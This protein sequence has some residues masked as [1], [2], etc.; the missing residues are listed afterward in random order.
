[1]ARGTK[2]ADT[3]VAIGADLTAYN[4]GLKQAEQGA[5]SL[6][7]KIREAFRMGPGGAARE[8]LLGPFAQDL[9]LGRKLSAS[10]RDEFGRLGTSARSVGTTIRGAFSSAGMAAFHAGLSGIKT[11]L[12]GIVSAAKEVGKGLLLGLGAAG[13]LQIAEWVAQTVQAIPNLINRGKEYANVVQE[14]AIQTGSSTERV[15]MLAAT[16]QYLGV[17]IQAIT[18]TVTTFSRALEGNEPLLK[19]LGVSLTDAAGKSLDAVTI[20]DRVRSAFSK[21]PA[22]IDRTKLAVQLF[23]E[24]GLG[25]MGQY[26]ALTDEQVAALGGQ[27]QAQALIIGDAEGKIALDAERAWSNVGNSLTGLGATLATAVLPTLTRVFD[28]IATLI[29]DNAAAIAEFAQS[30]IG[31]VVGLV[32]ALTGIQVNMA[33]FTQSVTAA[34]DVTGEGSALLVSYNAELSV[35]EGQLKDDAKAQDGSSEARKRGTAAIDKQIAALEKLERQQERTYKAALKGLT[36]QLDAQLRLM[37][38]QDQAR[39][40]ADEDKDLQERILDARLALDAIKREIAQA[41]TDRAQGFGSG[42]TL[43]QRTR[44]EEAQRA[45]ADAEAAVGETARQ[46]AEDDRRTQIQGLKDYIAEIDAIVSDAD[47][48]MASKALRLK[49]RQDALLAGGAEGAAPGSDQALQLA[50]VQEAIKRVTDAGANDRKRSALEIKRAE[51]AEE[52]AAVKKASQEQLRQ[53]IAD[54]KRLRAEEEKRI[55]EEKAAHLETLKRLRAAGEVI[56]G[57]GADSL[58]TAFSKAAEAGKKMAADIEIALWGED[59]KGGVL[60]AV[61]SIAG[62]IGDLFSLEA[63]AWLTTLAGLVAGGLIGGVPG[64]IVGGAGGLGV[65]VTGDAQR[66]ADEEYYGRVVPAYR[67]ATLRTGPLSQAEVYALLESLGIDRRAIGAYV[68]RLL[69]GDLARKESGGWAGLHGPEITLLGEKGP[70]FVVPNNV[71][72]PFLGGGGSSGMGPAIFGQPAIIRLE[73]GGQKLMDYIDTQL[74]LRPRR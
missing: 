22:D 39:A 73:I 23:G 44:L 33:S 45:L 54:L 32:S 36:D 13:G 63:P 42:P 71:V 25:R 24:G 12:G 3:Y 20:I 5:Q 31:Y 65:G 8:G 43:D 2:I 18:Q 59:G 74:A 52:T 34:G 15:S 14:I 67:A 4:Q 7:Q 61:Q 48:S 17:P 1:M 58:P 35:L 11:V 28:G 62:A 9:A 64:A 30:V 16:L 27:F 50:A 29:R 46:R 21:L 6:G 72:K 51:L 68:K 57:T 38:A 47:L 49:R 41:I 55:A 56:G 40:R 66:K 26:L 53:R 37:D 19:S 60:A 10:L 70:E 69:G